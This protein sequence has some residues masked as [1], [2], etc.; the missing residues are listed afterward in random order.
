MKNEFVAIYGLILAVSGLSASTLHVQQ[1]PS[2]F[3]TLNTHEQ[4]CVSFGLAVKSLVVGILSGHPLAQQVNNIIGLVLQIKQLGP[5]P[6][7]G[8][9][10]ESKQLSGHA[11]CCNTKITFSIS[12]IQLE[13]EL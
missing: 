10:H 4:A 6:K 7:D 12:A 11:F 1:F 8:L 2:T 13:L 5:P 3:S 9:S